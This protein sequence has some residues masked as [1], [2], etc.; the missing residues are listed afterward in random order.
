MTTNFN[1]A[2]DLEIT[3]LSEAKEEGGLWLR[4]EAKIAD[5]DITVPVGCWADVD[6]DGAVWNS[7]HE[8]HRVLVSLV[9]GRPAPSTESI[10]PANL[11]DECQSIGWAICAELRRQ[12]A[13]ELAEELA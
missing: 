8:G 4:G 6:D 13:A 12:R 10:P 7:S 11:R 5:T 1:L 9:T 2:C 3:Y